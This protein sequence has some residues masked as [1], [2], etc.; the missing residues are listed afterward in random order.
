MLSKNPDTVL[1]IIWTLALANVFGALACLALSKQ[2]AKLCFINP[3]ILTPFL[4]VI[5]LIGAYQ[6]TRHWGDLIAFFVLGLLGWV[7]KHLDWPRAPFLIG[8]VLSTAVERYLWIS[9][10]RYQW[11]WT[12]RPGVI[13]VAV[14]TVVLIYVGARLKTFGNKEKIIDVTQKS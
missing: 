3:A 8:F 7:M 2:V 11:A 9:M 1:I 10:E 14:L 6:S 13:A 5:M 4:L 12:Y